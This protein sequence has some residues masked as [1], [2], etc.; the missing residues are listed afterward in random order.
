MISPIIRFSTNLGLIVDALGLI[1]LIISA[2]LLGSKRKIQYLDRLALMIITYFIVL[3]AFSAILIGTDMAFEKTIAII[4]SGVIF[5]V[6]IFAFNESPD[7]RVFSITFISLSFIFTAIS[8]QKGLAAIY[9]MRLLFSFSCAISIFSIYFLLEG[10]KWHEKIFLFMLLMPFIYWGTLSGNR[11]LLLIT[12]LIISFHYLFYNRKTFKAVLIF[13]PLS[14]TLGSLYWYF[15]SETKMITRVLTTLEAGT[16]RE[17]IWSSSLSGII[18]TFPIGAGV[19]ESYHYLPGFFWS[20]NIFL[21]LLL[22]FGVFS[23]PI[24]LVVGSIT[25]IAIFSKKK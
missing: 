2:F 12:L 17:A 14:G 3:V 6:T 23:I 25:L 5:F 20:H 13:V 21:E 8:F 11:S 19:N 18:E 4:L 10:T 16:G 9:E 7:L 15:F 22:E 24:I 1:L